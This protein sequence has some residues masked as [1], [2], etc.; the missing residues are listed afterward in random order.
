MNFEKFFESVSQSGT[1][2]HFDNH[3]ANQSHFLNNEALFQLPLISL[4]IL[5]MAKNIRKPRV[6]EIGQLVG[7]SIEASMPGFKGSAQHVGWS[8]NLRVRT[9]KAISFLEHALLIEIP[10]N[11]GRIKITVLGKKVI[12]RALNQ[13][14]TLA[15]NLAEISKAY[16]NLCVSKQQDMELE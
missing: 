10:N 5:L 13:E 2:I 7:E 11:K 6:A 9:V 4:I 12:N 14:D 16:R 1:E 8:A 3:E 15:Y